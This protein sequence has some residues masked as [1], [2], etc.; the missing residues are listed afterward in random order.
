MLEALD[1]KCRVIGMATAVSEKNWLLL[2]VNRA[3]NSC[4]IRDLEKLIA[5]PDCVKG[6]T[7]A[8]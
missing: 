3:V 4:E 5:Q 7:A 8:E 6:T 1:A 2:A